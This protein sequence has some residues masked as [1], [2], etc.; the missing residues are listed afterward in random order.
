VNWSKPWQTRGPS[1]QPRGG[2]NEHEETM[3]KKRIMTMKW[4]NVHG[5]LVEDDYD[6]H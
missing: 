4:R 1:Q 6:D 3:M 5:D 2:T